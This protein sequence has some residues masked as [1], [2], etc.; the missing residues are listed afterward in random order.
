MYYFIFIHKG[1]LEIPLMMIVSVLFRI[2][3]SANVDHN[4]TLGQLDGVASTNYFGILVGKKTFNE[5]KLKHF[6]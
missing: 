4:I 5:I 2:I 3:D 1:Y 6:F